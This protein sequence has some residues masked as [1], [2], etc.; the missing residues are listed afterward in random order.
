[1][2]E[3]DLIDAS[4]LHPG[5]H[6]VSVD[7]GAVRHRLLALPWVDDATVDVD[8]WGTVRLAVTER[9][10][11]AALSDGAGAFVLADASGRALTKVP[12]GTR[13]GRCHH[14]RRH[15]PRRSG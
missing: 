15:R 14:R 10:P 13:P 4:G 2:S 5:D 12:V 1:M 7:P 9:T 11:V 6:L 8:W 3:Q